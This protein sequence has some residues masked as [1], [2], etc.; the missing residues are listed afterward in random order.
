[1]LYLEFFKEIFREKK[2]LSLLFHILHEDPNT[3]VS[4][5]FETQLRNKT[6]KGLGIHCIERLDEEHSFY[7]ND[8]NKK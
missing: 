2:R 6:Q 5:F 8:K 1:M 4:R 7:E 3:L